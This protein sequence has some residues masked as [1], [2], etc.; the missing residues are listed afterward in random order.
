MEERKSEDCLRRVLLE[1]LKTAGEKNWEMLREAVRDFKVGRV[2]VAE[3]VLICKSSSSITVPS[4]KRAHYRILAHPPRTGS[5][6][7]LP[8]LK[9][10]IVAAVI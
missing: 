3:D 8:C 5:R 7:V 1:W 4:R 9:T 2:G 6:L 10:I